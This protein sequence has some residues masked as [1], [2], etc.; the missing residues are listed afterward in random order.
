MPLSGDLGT[1]GAPIADA[2]TLPVMQVT[3]ETELEVDVRV[4]DTET[5]PSVGV[6]QAQEL[7]DA[8]Y[9]AITGAAA[10]HITIP[11]A[12]SVFLPN[13]VVAITPSST[14]PDITPM[15]GDSLLRTAPSDA[16]QGDAIAAVAREH[17]GAE[18]VTSMFLDDDYGH[19]ISEPFVEGIED[20]GGDLLEAVGV[21]PE[22]HSYSADLETALADDPDVLLIVGFPPTGEQLLRDYY[23][24]FD[25]G[26]DIVVTDG[27]ITDDLPRSVDAPLTNVTGVA[28]GARGPGQ[29]AFT[30]LYQ[31]E[32][33]IK[34]GIFTAHAY[35]ATAVLVLASLAADT[36]EGPAISEQI[37]DVA[38]PG[39][40][41]ITPETFA[42]GAELAAAGESV[43][44]QGASSRVEFDENGDV[45]STTYDI[46]EVDAG[47][48]FVTET[49]EYEP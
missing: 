12:E 20:R 29:E 48:F 21:L 14:S 42:D 5:D 46:Y 37:R 4:E 22:Q 40:T 13:D 7:V 17:L 32:Y 16:W 2:A 30:Q 15:D 45:T 28:P 3:E 1:V 36:L 27:L 47:G 49:L 34:P 6:S 18:T 31:S 26:V 33:G 43:Q 25:T 24:D 44:Y 39:G 41:T 23:A 9:P 10:S 38:N 8:G 11:A 19:G 35:D